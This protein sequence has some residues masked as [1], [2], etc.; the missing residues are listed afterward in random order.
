MCIGCNGAKQ[1]LNLSTKVRTDCWLVVCQVLV[2]CQALGNRIQRGLCLRDHQPTLDFKRGQQLDQN[3]PSPSLN[4]L[5]WGCW[6]H[7]WHSSYR[8]WSWLKSKATEKIKIIWGV[9]II[10]KVETRI[11]VLMRKPW[12][13]RSELLYSWHGSMLKKKS[14]NEGS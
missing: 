6:L 1:S 8:T 9:Y 12:Y 11:T 10:L 13:P 2:L 3:N 4:W 7:G 14:L 5:T